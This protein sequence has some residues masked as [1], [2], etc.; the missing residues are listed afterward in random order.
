MVNLYMKESF[1][2]DEAAL[3]KWLIKKSKSRLDY[4]RKRQ[5]VIGNHDNISFLYRL[6]RMLV[7]SGINR[8][9][10][11][12]G[13]ELY[14]CFMGVAIT[15]IGALAYIS[16]GSVLLTASLGFL[17]ATVF[18]LIL[19]ILSGIYYTKLENGIMTF[20]NLVENFSKTET[21]IVQIFKKTIYYV[22]E[23]LVSILSEFCHEA[24]STGDVQSAFAN[25]ISCIENIKCR[26]IFRNLQ[27]CSKYEANYDMVIRDVRMSMIDYLA[28]K[29]ERKAIINNGRAEIVILYLSALGIVYLFSGVTDNM[30]NNLV[31]TF[32]GNIIL[33]YCIIV[34]IICLVMMIVFDKRG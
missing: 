23:P 28:V 2:D 24:E 26:E 29:A 21:D 14:L 5:V 13:A 33:F 7:Y 1:R 19:Y 27:V 11:G 22:E 8:L 17:T 10:P 6:D 30:I 34:T 32:I 25:L 3:K 18:Y 31:G 12:I 9:I 16:T 15:G 20:L 4:E